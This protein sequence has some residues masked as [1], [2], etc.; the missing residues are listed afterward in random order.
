ME[1]R[2]AEH[3]GFCLSKKG[4]RNDR[5]GL[6]RRKLYPIWTL[7]PIIHNPVVINDLC[8]RGVRIATDLSEV[9]SGTLILRTHGTRADE[10]AKISPEVHRIVDATCP[11]VR[12]AQEKAAEFADAGK[13]IIVFGDKN[14]PEVEF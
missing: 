5:K 3:M 9:T 14:H 2:L 12:K 8:E 4:N 13:N 1:I 7:G 11:F 6:G 10:W